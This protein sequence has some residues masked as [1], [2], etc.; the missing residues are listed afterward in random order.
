MGLE[1]KTAWTTSTPGIPRLLALRSQIRHD[2]TSA[3]LSA[4]CG[5][6]KPL[7]PA[8]TVCW[9]QIGASCQ[10]RHRPDMALSASLR[11]SGPVTRRTVARPCVARRLPRLRH[12]IASRYRERVIDDATIDEAGRRLSGACPPGTRVILF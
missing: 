6:M 10:P 3:G 12:G 7:R 5:D 8:T 2:L 4:I 9:A 11:L 1:P